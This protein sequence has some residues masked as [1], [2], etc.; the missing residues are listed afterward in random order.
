MKF[1]LLRCSIVFCIISFF[2]PLIFYG[3]VN[4]FDWA[5]GLNV[6]FGFGQRTIAVDNQKNVY[7]VGFYQDSTDFDPGV[8]AFILKSNG[9][10]D[11]F[12]LKLDSLG[13]FV[14]AKSIGG[15]GDDQGFSIVTD[16]N[17]SVYIAGQFEGAV[18]FDPTSGIN[19]I[20]SNGFYDIFIIKF[21]LSGN[22]I[23]TKTMGGI[24]NDVVYSMTIDS[25]GNIYTTGWFADSADFDPSV[26]TNLLTSNGLA[27]I[28]IQKL[29]AAGNFVWAKSVGGLSSEESFSICVDRDGNVYTTGWFYGGSISLPDPV[30]FDPG[31][32]IFNLSGFGN[33]D[34]F[35]QKLDSLGNFVWAKSMG[36]PSNDYGYSITIGSSNNLYITGSFNGVGYFVTDSLLGINGDDIFIQK[37]NSSG[38]LIWAKQLGGFSSDWGRSIF[39][40]NSEDV[41]VTGSFRQQ[42]DFD[43]GPNTTILSSNGTWDVFIE[44]LDSAGNFIWAKS[45]GGI[46]NDK[47]YSIYVDQSKNIYTSGYFEGL[48]DF[49]P[50]L[51]VF[52]INIPYAFFIQKLKFENLNNGM[53]SQNSLANFYI[54]PNPLTK[55]QNLFIK[56]SEQ[57]KNGTIK[58]AN[59]MGQIVLE[60]KISTISNIATITLLDINL[61]AGIYYIT[62]Q[63]KGNRSTEK[64]IITK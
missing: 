57:I 55:S 29:D 21:D 39:L 16:R 26:S 30:D 48:V 10:N 58:I 50:D 60:K 35:V 49:N 54:Y 37:L 44:K 5:K 56:V 40:D 19:N 24:N 62:I 59:T 15:S 43:S 64:L 38:N 23:W 36:G 7:T 51:G 20:I 53:H 8:G 14:W 13:N 34:I 2:A 46:Y 11:I 22:L 31:T 32:G 25:S 3:Q 61:P 27:D 52:N 41:Y 1:L 47:G 42:V 12:I 4:T 18:D 28:Y 33:F 45:F 17:G 63:A 9:N 6:S